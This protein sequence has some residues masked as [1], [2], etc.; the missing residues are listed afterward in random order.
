MQG[1][2]QKILEVVVALVL[3]IACFFS[4]TSY[5]TELPPNDDGV[6]N[7]GLAVGLAHTGTMGKLNKVNSIETFVVSNSREPLPNFITAQWIKLFPSLSQDKS[8]HIKQTGQQLKLL[9][10]PNLFLFLLTIVGVYCLTR[11]LLQPYFAITTVMV[12]S[13]ASAALAY[14]CMH[15]VFIS[16]LLTEFHGACL[17]VWFTWS[18]LCSWRKK[19]FHYA[20]LAGVLLGLL[21]LTKAAFLYISV[22]ML[23]TLLLL[24]LV[25]RM[26]LKTIAIQALVLIIMVLVILPWMW[27]NHHHFDAWEIA[28]RG[29]NVLLTRAYKSQMTHEEFKGAFY[30][31]APASLKKLMKNITG[32]SAAD[33]EKGGRLERFTRFFDSDEVCRAKGDEACAIGYYIKANIRYNNIMADYAKRYPNKPEKARVEGDKAAKAYAMQLIK[34][35]PIGHLKTSLVFAWRGAWP[36][37]K[38]D[39]RW[40][41]F[42]QQFLQSAWQEIMPFIGL[43]AMLMM[44]FLAIIKR[45]VEYIAISWLAASAFGFYALASHFIPRYSEMMLPIW[46]VCLVYTVAMFTRFLATPKVH[47]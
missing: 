1:S 35:N 40:F 13:I 29:P 4:L 22:V 18:W 15:P 17:A 41:K 42:E 37:N 43:I 28:G 2:K 7:L 19:S 34:S 12:V 11:L 5:I 46:I 32:Y 47:S 36:C 3:F 10:W 14:A 31:Y 24:L 39:G 9:K 45:N 30:A 6:D 21:V 26:P 23:V 38:V 25:W 20:A 33:R 44:A 8:L 27:R 16:T